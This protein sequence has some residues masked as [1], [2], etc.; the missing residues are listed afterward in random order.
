MVLNTVVLDKLEYSSKGVLFPLLL[1]VSLLS[2]IPQR[3]IA[4]EGVQDFDIASSLCQNW[5]DADTPEK[6]QEV[7]KACDQ[8]LALSLNPQQVELWSA[9]GH[10][11]QALGQHEEAVASFGRVTQVEP[12][13]SEAWAQQC[14]SLTKLEKYDKAISACETALRVDQKWEQATPAIALNYR[15]LAYGYLP[16]TQEALDS[17]D[18]ATW[19][20]PDYSEAWT[21]RCIILYKNQDYDQALTNCDR[22]LQSNQYWGNITPATAWLY[23][24]KINE[25]LNRYDQA[26]FSYNQA[27]ASDNQ[28]AELWTGYGM[29]LSR[30]GRNGE[31]ATAFTNAVTISPTYSLALAQQCAALNR[32]GNYEEAAK[33]CETALQK[34]DNQWGTTN[35]A[36]AWNQQGNSLTALGRYEEALAS[37]QRAIALQATYGDA[38]SNRAVTLW[39]MGR[40]DEALLSSNH[41]ISLNQSSSRAWY[42]HA[43][44]LTTLGRFEEA[45]AAY[46]QALY[47]D[48]NLGNASLL[49]EIW[50]NLSAL[51]VR[52]EDY[53]QAILAARSALAIDPKSSSALY[54]MALAEMALRRYNDAVRSY[55]QALAI[56]PENANFWAG[57][58][59]ALRYLSE[60]ALAKTSLEEALKLNPSHPQAMVNLE[61]V[62]QEIAITAPEKIN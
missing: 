11:L 50:T 34:G 56:N 2:A 54:N 16:K 36:V 19:I 29:L 13:N 25:D 9:R 18:K 26:L 58:G 12:T 6:Y 28:N 17:F 24:A 7:L 62:I 37:F 22:A 15:G 52:L 8:A 42:N 49:A 45:L 4:Q 21:S 55:D 47:G 27:L 59:I 14:I 57:K 46:Q 35:P 61:L 40:Y 43:R 23:R 32:V 51:W 38:W 41:A 53:N 60:Y 20:N 44:I 3:S 5:L 39:V 48:A 10:V 31:A 1:S 33:A 30:L